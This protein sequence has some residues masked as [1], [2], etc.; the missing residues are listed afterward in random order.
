[1]L[2]K[3]EEKEIKENIKGSFREEKKRRKRIFSSLILYSLIPLLCYF[4]CE[5][6]IIRSAIEH[7][8]IK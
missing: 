7:K 3:G 1:V 2:V 6:S 4:I 8:F 5:S